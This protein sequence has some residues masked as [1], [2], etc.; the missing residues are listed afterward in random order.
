MQGGSTDKESQQ[1]CRGRI[2]R[3]KIPSHIRFVDD[4]PMTAS[5]KIQKFRLREVHEDRCVRS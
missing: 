5:G 4:F 1:L 3:F 2:A